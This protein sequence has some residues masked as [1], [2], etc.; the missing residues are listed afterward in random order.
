MAT[1]LGIYNGA[2]KLIGERRLASLS[3][4]REPRRLMDDEWNDGFIDDLLEAGQWVFAIRSVKLEYSPSVEPDF[5]YRKSYNKPDDF[6]R[7]VA[8]CE[9]E[10]FNTPLT[11]YSDEAGFWFCDLETIFVKYVSND[12]AY[13]NDM[14]L[15][16]PSFED[17]AKAAMARRIVLSLTQNKQ[18]YADAQ[19]EERRALSE[20][21][22][23]DAMA[24]PTA[25]PPMGSWVRSRTGGSWNRRERGVR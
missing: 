2:L 20:A 12:A 1:Q 19:K 14:S 7:T 8:V 16:P 11:Q 15:W 17:Y 5:G 22:S 18:Q 13:G 9:D 25:F 10:Y 6:I 24:K 4:N 3:E 23:R 21:L